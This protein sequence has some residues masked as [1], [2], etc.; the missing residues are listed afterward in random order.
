MP[1]FEREVK[2]LALTP[3]L[4]PFAECEAFHGYGLAH[5]WTHSWTHFYYYF[6][7]TYWFFYRNVCYLYLKKSFDVFS[8]YFERNCNYINNNYRIVDYKA[9]Y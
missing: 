8:H 3:L 5:S 9:C 2:V 6:Y 7:N 1:L 4:S